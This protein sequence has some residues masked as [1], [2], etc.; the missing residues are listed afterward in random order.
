MPPRGRDGEQT[1]CRRKVEQ[2]SSA[3]P[4]EKA[5]F[6]QDPAARTCFMTRL[7]TRHV[8]IADMSAD[9]QRGK[10]PRFLNRKSRAKMRLKIKKPLNI[11][12]IRITL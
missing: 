6:L 3:K 8:K 9:R 5:L 4:E 11:N 1:L 7:L 12:E 2:G 10:N